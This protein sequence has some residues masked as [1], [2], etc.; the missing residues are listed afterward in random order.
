MKALLSFPACASRSLIFLASGVRTI[1]RSSC[2]LGGAYRNRWRTPSRPGHLVSRPPICR[3]SLSRTQADLTG[4]RAIRPMPCPQS[5]P[6]PDRRSFTLTGV[7][8]AARSTHGE[9]SSNDNFEATHRGFGICCLRFTTD[10]AA[11]HARLTSGWLADLYREGVE[12]SGSRS[13][14]FRTSCSLLLS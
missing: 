3:H 7:V 1:L 6:Q 11:R 14:G 9:G 2:R 8:D 12:P 10:V 5:R 13:E 4:S